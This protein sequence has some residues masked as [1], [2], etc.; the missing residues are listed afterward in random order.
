LLAVSAFVFLVV[1]YL[2]DSDTIKGGMP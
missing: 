1:R 2:T